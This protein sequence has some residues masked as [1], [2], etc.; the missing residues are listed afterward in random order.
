MVGV[1]PCL[2]ELLGVEALDELCY[3]FLSRDSRV[4]C[5]LDLLFQIRVD[6]VAQRKSCLEEIDSWQ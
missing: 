4:F 3:D 1:A 6:L 2:F 5:A